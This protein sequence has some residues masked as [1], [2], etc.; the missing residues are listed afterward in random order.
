MSLWVKRTKKLNDIAE[1]TKKLKEAMKVSD[2][3]EAKEMYQKLSGMKGDDV[4]RVRNARRKIESDYR[5]SIPLKRALA[6]D[7]NLQSGKSSVKLEDDD[8]GWLYEDETKD[9][10]ELLE[11]D[12]I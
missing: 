11:G 2:P 9:D 10:E 4:D 1:R 8:E 6:L 3:L 5:K 7:S 12:F